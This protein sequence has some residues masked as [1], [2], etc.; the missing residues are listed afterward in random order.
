MKNRIYSRREFLK[1]N[2]FV[3]AGTVL[4]MSVAPTVFANCAGDAGTPAILG[5]QPVRTKGWM[6]WP[7]WDPETDEE[8]VIEVLRSGIWSRASVV[9]EFEKKWAEMIGTKRCLATNNGTYA[10]ITSLRQLDIGAG[11]EVIKDRKSVV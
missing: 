2:S 9:D 6:D 1:Q 8:R 11:D 4:T 10:L 5:G 3:G 7:M